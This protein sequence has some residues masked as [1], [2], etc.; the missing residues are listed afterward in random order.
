M[1]TYKAP[2]RDIRFVL[3]EVLADVEPLPGDDEYG[4]DTVDAVLD[5]AAQICEEVLQPLNRSGDEEGSVLQNGVVRTPKG[6]K[7][8][9]DAFREGGWV[10]MPCAVEDGGQ[11]MPRL[12]HNVVKEMFCSANLAFG[13]FPGLSNG[14][15]AAIRAHAAEDLKRAY[16]PKLA[17]GEWTGTMCLTEPQCGTDLGLISTK[18][19]P[20]GDGSFAITG[21]KIFISCGDHDFTDN[22]V[23]LVLAKL[24]DAPEGVRGISLFLVP[25]RMPM[26]DGRPGVHNGVSTG[27]LEHKMGIKASPTCVLNFE[28][29]I[30]WLVG[31]AHRG[32]RCM[33][34]M[35]NEARLSVGMQGLGLAEVAYQNARDYAKERGQGRSVSG[36]KDAAKPADPIIVHPDVRK[37]LLSIRSFTEGA[38]AMS[39]WVGRLLDEAEKHPDAVKREAADELVQLLTPIVKA[40]LTDQG[41]TSTVTAQ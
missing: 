13:M 22:I 8:A 21:T 16:L 25:K 2:L 32:M 12:L 4:Q 17:T 6:F 33:F 27:A 39:Y 7:E 9:Y 18:A 3:N 41:F 10:G 35:M 23:H 1:A 37:N 34:T 15:Y 24:P 14:A 5:A 26:A 40:Y 19:M 30:G 28:S 38:R 29:S 11:G 20:K 31:G 36:T